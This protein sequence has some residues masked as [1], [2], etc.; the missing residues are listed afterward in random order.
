MITLPKYN[1]LVQS[2]KAGKFWCCKFADGPFYLR[3]FCKKTKG[4]V[5]G[6]FLFVCFKLNIQRCLLKRYHACVI[7][8]LFFSWLW[9]LVYF[10]YVEFFPMEM[11]LLITRTKTTTYVN[12]IIWLI[13]V[14]LLHSL[15]FLLVLH[16]GHI[17]Y[18]RHILL[19]RKQLLI[20]SVCLK[21]WIVQ[22]LVK[23]CL[24]SANW[25][26]EDTRVAFLC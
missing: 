5:G 7:V 26:S 18:V 25:F 15:L 8:T 23:I 14:H 9:K 20:P 6:D 21:S 4:G 24:L 17:C 2:F 10:I 3:D 11:F 22:M 1:K 12:I 16:S 13:Q 19:H